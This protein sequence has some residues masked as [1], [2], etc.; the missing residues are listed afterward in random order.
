M[1]SR[2]CSHPLKPLIKTVT[3]LTKVGTTIAIAALDEEGYYAHIGG[4]HLKLVSPQGER[5][6]RIARTQGCL[7]KIV[8]A[9]DAANAVEPVSVME[10]HHC[11]GHIAVTSTCKLVESGAIVGVELD[12][13]SQEKDCDACIF[14]R[15]TRLSIPKVRI[16]A[17][18]KNF[19]DEV[20]TDVWGLAT[21]ATCQGRRYFI[22]FTDDTTSYTT[23]FLLRTKDEAFE[24]Y[25]RFE[26]W[27]TTQQHCRAIKVLH[28][29]Q[30]GEYL[31]GTF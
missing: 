20:H 24:A 11:L 18:A 1:A 29:N 21:I 9:L 16:S 4:S 6:G 10:L 31:S 13:T 15:A 2:L 30:G 28:S 17:P 26:A 7:Y 27:A 22:T 12:P 5:I 3:F 19:G 25:K 23:T 14:A 8:H